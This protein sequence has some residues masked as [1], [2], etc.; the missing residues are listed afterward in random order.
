[1]ALTPK[2]DSRLV[3]H[4]QPVPNAIA[5]PRWLS[6]IGGH[7]V[8]GLSMPRHNKTFSGFASDGVMDERKMKQD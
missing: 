4:Y 8:M 6:I 1:M 7:T 5:N 2:I 3:S